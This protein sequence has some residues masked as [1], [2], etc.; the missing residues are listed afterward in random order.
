VATVVVTNFYTAGLRVTE[1]VKLVEDQRLSLVNTAAA[2]FIT[3]EAVILTDAIP[4]D[5]NNAP[6]YTTAEQG[7][8]ASFSQSLVNAG[9]LFPP[10][11]LEFAKTLG[12]GGVGVPQ[13]NPQA[14]L[15]K[16]YL[17][18]AQ[19]LN[20]AAFKSQPIVV[21]RGLTRG[22]PTYGA[23][24]VGNGTLYRLNTDAYG[25]P[26]EGG[27]AET[28]NFT[29]TN[30]AQSGTLSGQEVFKAEGQPFKDALSWYVSGYG[31][32]LIATGQQG[33]VGISADTTQALIQNSSFS[34]FTGTGATSSFVLT[35]WT[36]TSGLAASMSVDTT[37]Y[38]RASQ[39]EGTTP[40]SL[41]ITA[42]V[43]IT[44]KISSNSGAIALTAFLNQIA[45][46]A[47]IGTAVGSFTVA[48]GSKSWSHTFTGEVGWKTLLPTL[49]K[50]LWA[51]NFEQANL[52]VTLTVTLA[53][54]TLKL[55][56]FCWAPFQNIGGSL[57]WLV[58]GTTAWIV[59]DTITAV[60]T[61]PS[62]PKKVANW[63]RLSQP[64]FYLPS[65]A[66]GAAPATAPT[67]A[68]SATG[69][70]ITAG[71]HRFW[72]SFTNAAGET[73]LGPPSAIVVFDGTKAADLSAIATG[74]GG[75]TNRYLY[76]SKADDV[77]PAATPYYYATVAGNATTTNTGGVA[78]ASLL[79]FNGTI[80]EPL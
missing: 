8:R 53:S 52:A 12:L 1:S 31:S 16:L 44:Q 74:A 79:L 9:A 17:F 10:I 47:S 4:F 56:D 20:A 77:G 49:D 34:Q 50:N 26:L 73:A 65:A 45:Y 59:N 15:A 72:V 24:N 62:P 38:Y 14:A 6:A 60:D 13:V 37:N 69:G 66:V 39:Q 43:T 3:Q 48:I 7:L 67:V 40:G 23:S 18:M 68:V 5:S 76:M 41:S 75:T 11:W 33:L 2:G 71:A 58:G 30:D 27:F 78:D 64:G 42:S 32:G 21:S 19:N 28:I 55:D 70:T 29:C 61:E 57:F 22:T 80:A 63:I 51:I 36:Q 54:G 25:F 46:N 35:G